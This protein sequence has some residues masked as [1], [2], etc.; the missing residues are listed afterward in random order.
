M[1]SKEKAFTTT[2]LSKAYACENKERTS[3]SRRMIIKLCFT[4]DTEV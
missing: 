4:L 1:K 3:N 2:R